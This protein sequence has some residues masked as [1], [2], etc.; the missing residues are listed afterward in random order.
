M[1][2][3]CYTIPVQLHIYKKNL[4]F[5]DYTLLFVNYLVINIAEVISAYSSQLFLCSLEIVSA[6]KFC[7]VLPDNHKYSGSR[8]ARQMPI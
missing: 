5:D 2:I 7:F 8:V 4:N 3:H 1:L 6:F